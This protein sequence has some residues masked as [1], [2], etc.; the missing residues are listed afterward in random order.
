MALLAVSKKD[1]FQQR[2]SPLLEVC[3]QKLKDKNHRQLSFEG[4]SVIIWIQLFKHPDS[5]TLMNQRIAYINRLLFPQQRKYLYPPSDVLLESFAQI[6]RFS[7][8]KLFDLCWNSQISNLLSHVDSMTSFDGVYNE[9]VI[10][11]IKAFLRISWDLEE[12]RAPEFPIHILLRTAKFEF[13]SVE[14]FPC[15][16]SLM[17]R[18]NFKEASEKIEQIMGKLLAVLKTYL[19][20]DSSWQSLRVIGDSIGFR[21]STLDLC[22]VILD[23]IPRLFPIMPSITHLIKVLVKFALTMEP[24]IRTSAQ[25]C[26]MRIVKYYPKYAIE[27]LRE[28]CDN[29]AH[30]NDK[31]FDLIENGLKLLV[32]TFSLFNFSSEIER[33]VLDECITKSIVYSL[34]TRKSIRQEAK[35]LSAVL[36]KFDYCKAFVMDISML[37]SFSSCITLIASDFIQKSTLFFS[38]LL[39][40]PTKRIIVD[41]V[42][43]E[44]KMKDYQDFIAKGAG[45]NEESLIQWTIYSSV[46]FFCSTFLEKEDLDLQS[47]LASE[48]VTH[49]QSVPTTPTASSSNNAAIHPNSNVTLNS[50]WLPTSAMDCS[51]LVKNWLPLL[52]SEKEISRLCAVM[53]LKNCKNGYLKTLLMHLEKPLRSIAED[54]SIPSQ[55][56]RSSSAKKY[57][58]VIEKQ[59][60]TLFISEILHKLKFENQFEDRELVR[61]ILKFIKGIYDFLLDA[62]NQLEWDYVLI[63]VHFCDLVRNYSEVILDSWSDCCKENNSDSKVAFLNRFISAKVRCALFLALESWSGHGEYQAL[64]REKEAQMMGAVLEQV[65]DLKERGQIATVLEEQR[66]LLETASLN[67]LVTLCK[68]LPL[69]RDDKEEHQPTRKRTESNASVFVNGVGR[70]N[71]STETLSSFNASIPISRVMEWIKSIFL[72][73]NELLQK[74]GQSALLNLLQN[75]EDSFLL[76]HVFDLL[77]SKEIPG[78]IS[79][80]L[81]A[82]VISLMEQ[83]WI[84]RKKLVCSEEKMLVFSI[85]VS[86]SC[87]ERHQAN[88]LLG[89]LNEYFEGFFF[90]TNSSFIAMEKINYASHILALFSHFIHKN[91]SKS[92]NLLPELFRRADVAQNSNPFMVLISYCMRNVILWRLNVIDAFLMVQNL[93]YFS[94]KHSDEEAL[95]ECWINLVFGN[96]LQC[97]MKDKKSKIGEVEELENAGI[98]CRFLVGMASLRNSSRLLICMK[99]IISFLMVRKGGLCVRILTS[100]LDFNQRHNSDVTFE[101]LYSSLE[102]YCSLCDESFW[103]AD[104]GKFVSD[105]LVTP[106]NSGQYSFIL[107]CEV[108]ANYKTLMEPYKA[109]II[110]FLIMNWNHREIKSH[111]MMMLSALGNISVDIS[112][113]WEKEH[114]SLIKK[115]CFYDDSS[116]LGRVSAYWAIKLLNDPIGSQSWTLFS[117]LMPCFSADML[118]PMLKC[119]ADLHL[120]HLENLNLQYEESLLQAIHSLSL[121]LECNSESL[122]YVFIF[123]AIL[124]N[125][126]RKKV[127]IL[128][129]SIL[130]TLFDRGFF[131]AE[132]PSIPDNFQCLFETL[133]DLILKGVCSEDS[134]QIC[135]RV[136]YKLARAANIFIA[137]AEDILLLAI[138]GFSPMLVSSVDRSK[139]SPET[140]DLHDGILHFIAETASKQDKLDL[141]KLFVS[142][143]KGKFRVLEDFSQ[144]LGRLVQKYYYPGYC[145]QVLVFYASFLRNVRRVGQV[146]NI[147]RWLMT[148]DAMLE[149]IKRQALNDGADY[150]EIFLRPI[151]ECLKGNRKEDLALREE[152]NTKALQVLQILIKTLASCNADIN[153][154]YVAAEEENDEYFCSKIFSNSRFEENLE[155]IVEMCARS[156]VKILLLKEPQRIFTERLLGAD[157]KR[158][159]FLPGHSL[160]DLECALEVEDYEPNEDDFFPLRSLAAKRESFSASMNLSVDSIESKQDDKLKKVGIVC[161]LISPWPDVNLKLTGMGHPNVKHEKLEDFDEIV[162]DSCDSDFLEQLKGLCDPDYKGFCKYYD[163]MQGLGMILPR[164]LEI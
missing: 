121:H 91:P 77:Y 159:V 38:S 42:L 94:L 85:H 120:S 52:T 78:K 158:A 112:E 59:T 72:S 41:L 19:F 65:R 37:D 56:L 153:H 8:Y 92:Y 74:H 126:L 49:F 154:E 155:M 84:L 160:I 108:A 55:K 109:E 102:A 90:S 76:S 51:L 30:V 103:M 48:S 45:I 31:L 145:Y 80:N 113:T 64:H 28:I 130:E 95:R 69:K 81:I 139:M 134:E 135:F 99:K 43:K 75:S 140:L 98:I 34:S 127:Y 12:S 20:D 10:V 122:F 142:L 115:N 63:R 88:I 131:D 73:P 62:S 161:K 133:P 50:S 29:L 123:S 100:F 16:E 66:K 138:I 111:S 57:L 164:K 117:N 132:I 36:D 33:E 149:F 22:R 87:F 157:E 147:F 118:Y 125:S 67:A 15:K 53:V 129:L 11:A 143:A 150:R 40:C 156:S 93:V 68:V 71:S 83:E 5:S 2:F 3:I 44:I 21:S 54:T 82:S 105:S 116:D 163:E 27:I 6:I 70:G 14:S 107:L 151:L 17:K 24:T 106:M 104:F 148:P 9:R 26:I 1:S 124:L 119:Y 79:K 35:N 101:S 141:A 86:I 128:G 136:F 46:M 4:I 32:A 162:V 144:Q 39:S 23:A 58:K 146:L 137:P 152:N 89:I 114:L 7:G 97:L 60:F 13:T 18:N 47:R 110:H 25:S 61:T 96:H